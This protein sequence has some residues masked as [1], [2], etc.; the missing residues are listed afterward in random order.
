MENI[1]KVITR[2]N[3]SPNGKARVFVAY[4]PEDKKYLDDVIQDVFSCQN[5]AVYYREDYKKE[6][7]QEDLFFE[8]KQM[9][10]LVLVVTENFLKADCSAFNEFEF[11]KENNI[12]ILPLLYSKGIERTFNEVCGN[13]QFLDKHTKDLTAID[14]KKKLD[15]Y[16]KNIL[17][18]DT[19]LERI[20]SSFDAYIFLSYRK[21]DRKYANEFMKRVHSN[22]ELRD[23]AIWY[24]EFL[25]PGEDFNEEI[26]EALQKSEVFTLLVTPNLVNEINYVMTHEYPMA[27]ELN[28]K[29][30]PAEAVETN[31]QKLNENYKNLPEIIDA[32]NS[33]ILS[34]NLIKNLKRLLTN[35]T[36]D[37]E[38]IYYI[39]LAYLL[40]IDV[41]LDSEKAIKLLERSAEKDFPPAY[42]KLATMYSLGD[43]VP[44]D[45]EKA[46]YYREKSVTLH[47]KTFDELSKIKDIANDTNYLT[48]LQEYFELMHRYRSAGRLKEAVESGLTALSYYEKMTDSAKKEFEDSAFAI[49]SG[50]AVIYTKMHNFDDAEKVYEEIGAFWKKRAEEDSK[51][52][53]TYAITL[54]QFGDFYFACK[55]YKK[56]LEL[57]LK[58]KETFEKVK[59]DYQ[60]NDQNV[61]AMILD[62]LASA[63]NFFKERKKAINLS[64]E[65]NKIYEKLT[66]SQGVYVYDYAISLDN[67]GEN[68]KQAGEFEKAV[69]FD[70]K[71][72]NE[73]KKLYDKSPIAYTKDYLL[74]VSNLAL[75]YYEQKDY[76]NAKKVMDEAKRCFEGAVLP[77]SVA[78]SLQ[79]STFY[80]FYALNDEALGIFDNACECFDKCF[81]HMQVLFLHEPDRYVNELIRN[82][83]CFIRIFDEDPP[84]LEGVYQKF[85]DLLIKANESGAGYEVQLAEVYIK[86]AEFYKSVED[87][88]KRSDCLFEIINIYDDLAVQKREIK[89][90][91]S[92]LVG[93]VYAYAKNQEIL[94]D[95]D[96]AMKNLDYA[97]YLCSKVEEKDGFV[98][99]VMSNCGFSL[100]IYNF[101]GDKLDEAIKYFQMALYAE[102]E[103]YKITNDSACM[104]RFAQNLVKLAECYLKQEDYKN[105]KE[106][107]ADAFVKFFVLCKDNVGNYTENL[108]DFLMNISGIERLFLNEDIDYMFVESIKMFENFIKNRQALNLESAVGNLSYSYARI[109]VSRER[110]QDAILYYEK[111]I[112]YFM[113]LQE[114][115]GSPL[116]GLDAVKRELELIYKEIGKK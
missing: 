45:V 65:A 80:W 53:K 114:Q 37:G 68:Y 67:V 75:L 111:A 26:K 107:F 18:D 47:Q 66:K 50:L 33:E 95:I 21:K 84:L 4:H 31:K 1:L 100:G 40:G 29:V 12:P 83:N 78:N 41:E 28:K 61:Y 71:G 20:R 73:W 69:E 3:T 9:S 91:A 86:L 72:L 36:D 104:F 13:L 6:V 7:N 106:M 57:S 88:E 49:K 8:L 63:Y 109:L 74:S 105:A 56:A 112:E 51:F 89:G 64:L 96:G 62:N 43:R 54:L 101:N 15:D 59:D 46:L 30:L 25:S 93:A 52:C 110:K 11:A 23:V 99:E 92:G 90:L 97:L 108:F 24:D 94:G 10:L 5:C 34:E 58:A 116:N 115:M 102:D 103:G 35:N 60:E 98:F 22:E 39:A 48:L 85:I 113:I 14:Y 44:F 42:Q 77:E 82:A 81:E 70:K 2:D 16:L 76:T 27:L 38:H 32:N 19:L 87:Y 79:L 55:N 17:V